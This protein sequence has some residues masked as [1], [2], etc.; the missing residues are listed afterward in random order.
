VHVRNVR[1]I[2][3]L[4]FHEP[5]IEI[6]QGMNSVT[7]AYAE[8]PLRQPEPGPKDVTPINTHLPSAPWIA[9]GPPLSPFLFL[10]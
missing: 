6:I 2:S 3:L 1:K 7:L 10:K 4:D 9:S 5:M 8:G